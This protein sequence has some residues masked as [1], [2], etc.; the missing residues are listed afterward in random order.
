LARDAFHGLLVID[1][2]TG[3]T[4]RAVVDRAQRWFPRGTR[5]G[6]TGTLDPLASGVLVLCV[7]AATRLTEYVQRMVKTYRAGILFGARSD[8][9]DADGTITPS[10]AALAPS[11]AELTVALEGFVGEIE[12]VP[13][14]YSAAHVSGRRAYDLARRGEEVSLTPRRVTIYRIRVEGYEYPQLELTV[15]CGKGTYIRA[16]ARDLGERLGCGG[17]IASLR[18]TRVGSFD[19]SQA[20]P[21]DSDRALAQARL[22][23][24]GMAVVELPRIILQEEAAAG[25]RHGRPL[26]LARDDLE[27]GQ[28]AAVIDARGDLLAVVR[29][30]RREGCLRPEKVF[31]V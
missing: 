25:L 21:L 4:S 7:G 17:Y 18:R 29:A 14:A 15:D 28:E 31:L 24:P 10:P 13:P 20:L 1:K 9:D 23:P 26:P 6:H 19:E 30:D 16:L 5:L 22:R 3:I 2:P 27:D 12:Q 11:Q 8:T